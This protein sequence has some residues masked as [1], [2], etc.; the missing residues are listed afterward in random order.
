MSRAALLFL[1]LLPVSG[2]TVPKG[3]AD[4]FLKGAPLTFDQVLRLSGENAIPLQRRKQAIQN[5]GVDFSPTPEQVE[6]LR[7]AGASDDVLKLI[8]NKAKP[9]TPPAPRTSK[10][11]PQGAVAVTCAPL[12]CEISINGTSL[13][14]TQDGRL[15]MAKLRPGNWAIDFKK[16]GYISHQ[17]IVTVEAGHTIPVTV[18]LDPARATQEAFGASLFERVVKALGG[19][20]SLQALASMQATGSTTIATSD[21]KSVRWTLVMRNRP[22]RGLFQIRAG[23]GIL[24]EVAFLG[25]E[26]K[27]SKNWKGQ[28]ALDLPT[29]FGLVRD[30]QLPPLIARLRNPQFKI[31]ANHSDPVDGEEYSLFAEDGAEKIAIGLDPELRPQRVRIATTAGVGS[32]VITYSDYCKTEKAVYPKTIEIKPD[33]WKQGIDVRFDT[34]TLSPKLTDK[35]YNLRG[36]PLPDLG[37]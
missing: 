37:K 3:S 36:K 18:T 23:G 13:G 34:V 26:F 16:A 33:G 4:P 31:L 24:R 12:E 25:N 19:A 27:I 29:G 15:E 7:A 22:D 5:R 10:P 8:R 28:E 21:G 17:T 32:S 1:L 11:D 20:E 30:N 14:P 2:Q 6:K 35:D 9:G